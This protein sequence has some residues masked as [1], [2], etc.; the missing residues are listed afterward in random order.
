MFLQRTLTVFINNLLIQLILKVS[1]NFTI[2]EIPD[3]IM[4]AARKLNNKMV[5]GVDIY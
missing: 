2:R 5:S 1:N 4:A 3:D